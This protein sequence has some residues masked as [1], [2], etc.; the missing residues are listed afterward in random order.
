M[1]IFVSWS[2]TRSQAI[3]TAM[4]NW[5]PKLIDGIKLFHSE[6]IEKGSAWHPA[7]VKAL[8]DCRAGIF[9]ITPESLTSHWMLFEAG[10]LIQHGN[11]PT[12]LTY[13]Y[14]INELTGPLSH[15]KTTRFDRKDS[16][17]FVQRIAK[18]VGGGDANS[19]LTRFEETWPSFE[20]E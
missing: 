13:L 2:G 12:L 20:S 16:L 10:A 19:V 14:G 18:L 4:R 15:F 17:R 6:D 9:C 8:R 3:A 5:L 7:L 11:Q 1:R